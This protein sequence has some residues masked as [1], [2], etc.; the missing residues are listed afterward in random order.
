MIFIVHKFLLLIPDPDSGAPLEEIILNVNYKCMITYNLT[1]L[2][3]NNSDR[4]VELRGEP[5]K[6]RTFPRAIPNLADK[7]RV[8]EVLQVCRTGPRLQISKRR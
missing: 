5:D 7:R 3:G 8:A 1:E 6:P 4:S 2:L